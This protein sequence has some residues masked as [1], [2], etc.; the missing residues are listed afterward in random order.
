[1]KANCMGSSG[2]S[3]NLSDAEQH[4][5]WNM[6]NDTLQIWSDGTRWLFSAMI[7]VTVDTGYLQCLA[8]VLLQTEGYLR[9]LG[10]LLNQLVG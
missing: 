6:R 1:M 10:D 7:L 2:L 4:W 9:F 3:A 8:T 5:K